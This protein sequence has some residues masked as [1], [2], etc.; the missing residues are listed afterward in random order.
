MT[1]RAGGCL[2]R[3][4]ALALPAAGTESQA[5]A[6]RA[7]RAT[8]PR[9]VGEWPSLRD[10][11]AWLADELAAAPAARA[12]LDAAGHEL[13]ARQQA[14]PVAELLAPGCVRV[15]R[16]NALLGASDLEE[17]AREA[18]AALARGYDVLKVK[19]G[20]ADVAR[21]EARLHAVRR[22]AGARVGLRIDANGAWSREQASECL[23]RWVRFGL[24]LVEQP[25]AGSDLEGLARLARESAVPVAAD[26]AL[27][28]P[29]GREALVRGE[30]A[31]LAVLKP[32]VLGG[33]AA[34]L[35]LARRA[36]R[37]GVASL[38]TTTLDGPLGTAAALHLAA[39]VGGHA[40]A[41]G[42]AAADWVEAPF[43]PS[44]VPRS[45]RLEIA[46]GPGFGEVPA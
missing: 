34:A 30:L 1:L 8:A 17:T 15:V 10:W 28:A 32:A 7:L 9:C 6:E 40:H 31:P 26:E 13:A 24:E 41:H 14:A 2:G 11:L 38:V 23:M 4:E 37:S 35:D 42:L 46:R 20:D 25:V 12:A 3:G 27:A 18:E 5:E 21:D 44:L 36:A 29:E 19:V 33:L 43:A 45:G 16:A 22:I 39:A